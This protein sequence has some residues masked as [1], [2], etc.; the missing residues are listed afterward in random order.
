MLE[1]ASERLMQFSMPHHNCPDKVHQV[2]L[3]LEMLTVSSTAAWPGPA[4]RLSHVQTT[5]VHPLAAASSEA[6]HDRGSRQ[7]TNTLHIWHPDW[8]WGDA[9]GAAGRLVCDQGPAPALWPHPGV[10]AVT[11]HATLWQSD[12]LQCLDLLASCI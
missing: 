3:C 5:C 7:G 2:Q 4:C 1:S 6:G 12:T 10:F 8:H 11:L 9:C